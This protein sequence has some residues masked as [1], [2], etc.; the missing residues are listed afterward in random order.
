MKSTKKRKASVPSSTV[1]G[2]SAAQRVEA[3]EL[4]ASSITAM[5]GFVSVLREAQAGKDLCASV[6]T[7]AFPGPAPSYSLTP[8]FPPPTTILPSPSN[9]LGTTPGSLGKRV[10]PPAPCPSSDPA[11]SSLLSNFP[12]PESVLLW[13]RAQPAYYPLDVKHGI[14]WRTCLDVR[15]GQAG[16]FFISV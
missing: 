6:R 4:R 9:P 15:K 7:A 3:R 13:A 1:P 11:S 12:P 16:R 2:R 14:P 5:N 8:P 10:R